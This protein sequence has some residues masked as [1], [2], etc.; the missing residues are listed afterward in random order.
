MIKNIRHVGI[1]V[2]NLEI[3]LN[4]YVKILGLKEVVKK[5]LKGSYIENLL[6]IKDIQLTYVKLKTKNTKAL[7]ELWYFKQPKIVTNSNSHISLTVDNLDK[8]YKK[9][10]SNNIKFLSEPII[11]PEGKNKLCFCFDTEGNL[12]ELVEELK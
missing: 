10:K 7:I 5:D 6:N 1:V 12:L 2:T 3:A 9:L 8:L 4:F 11:D